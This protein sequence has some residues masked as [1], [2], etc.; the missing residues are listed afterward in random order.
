MPVRIILADDHTMVRQGLR[1]ILES[2]GNITVIGE[3]KDGLEA[4]SMVEKLKPD[5]A[6]L[7]LMMPKLNGL[8]V[9]R[10]IAKSTHVLVVS[11]HANE[12]YV[13]EALQNGAYGYVLKDSSAQELIDA[14][15]KVANGSKYLSS[16]LSER[17]IDFYAQQQS[18]S[19]VADPYD[20][21]TRR[22][23]EIFQL[24]AEGS[25]NTEIAASLKISPRTV[26][27]HKSNVLHKLN[28]GNQTD[29]VRFALRRGILPLE[30]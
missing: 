15:L 26:E 8:E 10:Q 12:G 14:V 7:D 25:S 29:I 20:S 2:Q 1:A 6:V 11:M 3:A 21:L 27:I 18:K 30:D 28:L 5:V 4:Q 9:T 16:T 17:A 19:T 22:E 23:R 24:M 13:L